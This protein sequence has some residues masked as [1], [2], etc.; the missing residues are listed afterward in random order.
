MGN[1]IRTAIAEKGL[2]Q[3]RILIINALLR[4]RQVCCDPRLLPIEE[5]AG[6]TQSAKLEMLMNMLPEMVD[7]G[8][9]ILLFSQF[10]SMLDLIETE[11]KKAGIKYAKLT[12]QTRNRA[13]QIEKFQNGEA[14]LFLISLKAG[15]VGLNLTSADSVIH[16]DPWW[17]PA[18]EHQAT[19]RAHRIGQTKPLFVYKLITTD[20]VEEQIQAMQKRKQLLAD[21][22]FEHGS[23]PHEWWSESDLEALFEPLR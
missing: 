7:E 10:T 19:D 1:K 14:S 5:T 20:S 21:S 16:Y 6:A 13:S 22:L 12:G 8:R 3:C 17:N 18:V 11:V 9:Q 2:G 4:M 23:N 15:G